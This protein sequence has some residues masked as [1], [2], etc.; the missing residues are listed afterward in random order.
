MEYLFPYTLVPDIPFDDIYT[1]FIV[2]PGFHI[3]MIGV[4]ISN[5]L[6]PFM[7]KILPF[8]IAS[9]IGIILIPLL[10]GLFIGG[11]QWYCVGKLIN[12]IKSRHNLQIQP[13]AD[14]AA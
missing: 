7:F 8:R 12:R 14:R 4:K 9:V 3:Y 6:S 11:I 2:I 10:V 13:S 1:L 5:V